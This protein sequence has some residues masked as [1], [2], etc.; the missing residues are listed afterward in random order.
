M[1]KRVNQGIA[2]WQIHPLNLS[3]LLERWLKATGFLAANQKALIS[4]EGFEGAK[5]IPLS[6]KIGV[7]KEPAV[8]KEVLVKFY[9]GEKKKK[10]RQGN[11]VRGETSAST[12]P[13]S[14]E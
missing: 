5:F 6:V 13:G 14:S 3:S 7:D 10:L 12:A 4:V 1:E 2:Q 9:G 11:G 8:K